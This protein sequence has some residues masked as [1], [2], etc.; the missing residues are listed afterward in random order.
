MVRVLT[1]AEYQAVVNSGADSCD[2]CGGQFEVEGLVEAHMPAEDGYLQGGSTVCHPCSPH[3][4]D[5]PCQ[6][7]T[8]VVVR[9]EHAEDTVWVHRAAGLAAAF[10]W[11]D[12]G[13]P[14]SVGKPP[15]KENEAPPSVVRVEGTAES[16]HGYTYPIQRHLTVTKRQDGEPGTDDATEEQIAQA[17]KGGE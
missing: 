16:G 15:A 4:E 6:P 8:L 14:A 17:Q 5:G 2:C 1:Q 12:E 13:T 7:D 11:Q 9:D 10:G 3:A